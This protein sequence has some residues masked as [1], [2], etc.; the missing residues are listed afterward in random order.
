MKSSCQKSRRVE[1][2]L[3][4]WNNFWDD[5]CKTKIL[6]LRMEGWMNS[7]QGK[8]QHHIWHKWEKFEGLMVLSVT[9]KFTVLGKAS[10][11]DW[12]DQANALSVDEETGTQ[13]RGIKAYEKT[14][15]RDFRWWGFWSFSVIGDS[16][17]VEPKEKTKLS[18]LPLENVSRWGYLFSNSKTKGNT[19][20]KR[21]NLVQDAKL[22]WKWLTVT[23]RLHRGEDRGG[24]ILTSGGE[25]C[26]IA[27]MTMEQQ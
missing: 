4:G 6:I 10:W 1:R 14:I 20:R 23:E 8:M 21:N 22:I 2:A 15:W 11:R 9:V 12:R 17:F 25:D 7:Q 27:C 26:S 24:K 5:W 19:V 3:K 18:V 13:R 16:M